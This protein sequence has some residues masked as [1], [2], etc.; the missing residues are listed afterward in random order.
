MR[1]HGTGS[2]LCENVNPNLS[3]MKTIPKRCE[4]KMEHLAVL[5]EHKI[6]VLFRSALMPNL[7]YLKTI[8]LTAFRVIFV[9]L[10]EKFQ[11]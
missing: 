4:M 9:T 2:K 3:D 10:F 7:A 8:T 11:V 5:C 1:S 6:L